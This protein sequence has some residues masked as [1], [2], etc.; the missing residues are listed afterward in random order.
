MAVTSVWP[1]PQHI[2]SMFFWSFGYVGSVRYLGMACSNSL[3]PHL[4]ASIILALFSINHLQRS[5]GKTAW[6]LLRTFAMTYI[7]YASLTDFLIR[8]RSLLQALEYLP[9]AAWG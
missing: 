5:L 6:W 1:S 9:F 8:P 3:F 2:Q 7:D 4:R